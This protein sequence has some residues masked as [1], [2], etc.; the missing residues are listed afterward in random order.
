MRIPSPLYT[1]AGIYARNGEDPRLEER[2]SAPRAICSLTHNNTHRA[3][4]ASPPRTHTECTHAHLEADDAR[5][6]DEDL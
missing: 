5:P 1:R 4:R 3:P 2:P 6:G